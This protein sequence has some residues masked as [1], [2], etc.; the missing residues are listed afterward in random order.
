MDRAWS[1]IILAVIGWGL[2]STV[3]AQPPRPERP[4]PE[5]RPAPPATVVARVNVNVETNVDVSPDGPAAKASD[6][7]EDDDD[8]EEEDEEEETGLAEL[9]ASVLRQPGAGPGV[10]VIAD[11]K[12]NVET[13]VKVR[14]PSKGSAMKE[15]PRAAEAVKPQEKT[16]KPSPPTTEPPRKKRHKKRAQKAETSV[17]PKQEEAHS[18]IALNRL[19]IGD[20]LEVGVTGELESEQR[21][22]QIAQRINVGKNQTLLGMA[23]VGMMLPEQSESLKVVQQAVSSVQ[24]NA[25]GS[26]LSV[27]VAIPKETPGAVKTIVEAALQK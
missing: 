11:I 4:G 19:K 7:E 3:Q 18:R 20:T 22:N 6:D 23:F 2:V 15:P 21:A 5:H 25:T 13:S 14:L 1:L 27:S 9:V 12:V 17:E 8:D 16:E 10:Q 24:A 26:E